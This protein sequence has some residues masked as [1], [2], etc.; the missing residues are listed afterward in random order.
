MRRLLLAA[1]FV[2]GCGQL[3]QPSAD[4][5]DCDSAIIDYN[6]CAAAAHLELNDCIAADWEGRRECQA[7]HIEGLQFCS[8]EL[9][10]I[11]Q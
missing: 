11:C 10:A 2:T 1:L 4:P 6:A 9:R 7:I 3:E 5:V 8:D